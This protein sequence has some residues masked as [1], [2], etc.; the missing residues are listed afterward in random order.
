M[1]EDAADEKNTKKN[2]RTVLYVEG[3]CCPSEVPI[4]QNSLKGV[5]GVSEIIVNVPNKTTTVTYDPAVAN[6]D[7]FV[8]LLNR[9]N[10]GARIRNKRAAAEADLQAPA[11]KQLPR[12]NVLLALF[13]LGVSVPAALAD[14]LAYLRYF[15]LVSIAFAWPPIVQKAVGAARVGVLDINCLMVRGT[16]NDR[17]G[18]ERWGER[19]GGVVGG[20]GGC[21][22]CVEMGERKRE[23]EK[24][25][26]GL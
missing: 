20:E 3:I 9:A 8:L 21:T 5:P 16:G 17:E 18:G 2:L 11:W 4:I 22:E 26:Q 24:E 19:G 25:R 12:W 6:P 15:A 10:L 7:Q 1:A 23:R 13:F 14:D